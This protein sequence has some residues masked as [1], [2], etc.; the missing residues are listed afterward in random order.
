MPIELMASNGPSVD[1]SVVLQADLDPILQ[2]GLLHPQR[3]E[4]GLALGD[5]DAHGLDT[6][7]ACGVHHQAAPA[8][9]HVEQPHARSEREL[10]ADQL[11]LGIL[12]GVEPDVGVSQSAHE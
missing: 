10:L 9:A 4:L 2:A 7:V 8:T 5:R 11:V 1:V 3:A 12:G 6:V